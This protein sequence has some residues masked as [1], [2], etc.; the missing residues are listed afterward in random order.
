MAQRDGIDSGTRD[1]RLAELEQLRRARFRKS[2]ILPFAVMSLL[3]TAYIGIALALPQ[4]TQ[5]A[6][7]SDAAFSLLV[8]CPAA[9]CLFPFAIA[10]LAFAAF[11]QRKNPGTISPLRRLEGWTAALEGNVD[12]WL[13]NIDQ[14]V[15]NWAV[16]FAPMRQLLSSFD[17][18]P[19]EPSE[20]PSDEATDDSSV[21][22]TEQ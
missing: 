7:L 11:L 2:V 21:E 16:A 4:P 3:A 22:T 17:A 1:D 9:I 8:L 14:R 5:V 19:D 18:Q 12:R 10:M 15:L 6:A 13:G 20:D